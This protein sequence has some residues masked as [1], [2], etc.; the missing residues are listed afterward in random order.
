VQWLSRLAV[1]L[2]RPPTETR[3]L[4]G[5]VSAAGNGALLLGVLVLITVTVVTCMLEAF[6]SSVG[7][8][9][10]VV[11]ARD[12]W[13]V[14]YR[15][16]TQEE[17]C[18]DKLPQKVN[19]LASASNL[20]LWD[21]TYRR[22]DAEHVDR[23]ASRRGQD[24]WLGTVLST[25]AVEKAFRLKANRLILG[26][27][28]SDYEVWVDGEKI[29]FGEYL[30]THSPLVLNLSMSRL[31]EARP[32]TV[33]IRIIH[34]AGGLYPDGLGYFRAEG[35]AT[36]SQADRYL[37]VENFEE[38]TRPWFF[39]GVYF[40]MGS[41]FLVLWGMSPRKQECA[42]LAG[43]ALFQAFLQA[44]KSD[45]VSFLFDLGTWNRIHN[46]MSL[47]EGAFALFLGLAFARFRR[48]FFQWGIPAFIAAGIGL[49]LWVTDSVQAERLGVYLDAKVV[50][51]GYLLGAMACF[52][53]T[54]WLEQRMKQRDGIFAVRVRRLLLFGIGLCAIGLSYAFQQSIPSV[55]E[56]TAWPRFMNLI[57]VLYLSAVILKDY[58]EQEKIIERSPVS[59]YHRRP[60]LPTELSGIV[61]VVDIKRSEFLIRA[62]S[63]WGNAG[64]LVNTGLSHMW[65]AATSNEGTVLHSEG[66]AI[67]VFFEHER[68]AAAP[69][70]YRTVQ[71][72]ANALGRFV[73]QLQD[74]GVKLGTTDEIHF[75]A[76]LVEGVVR[77]VWHEYPGGRYPGWSASGTS[78]VFLEA[79]RLMEI[80]QQIDPDRRK[81]LL[82]VSESL[83]EKLPGKWDVRNQ[84]HEA[85]HGEIYT[86]AL[87]RIE[88]VKL[89]KNKD[90]LVS[91]NSGN[92]PE[93]RGARR[94]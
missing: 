20:A 9:P 69:R 26:Y 22:E 39:F 44:S 2:H 90:A 36:S 38:H 4:G 53:Q 61:L 79:A 85:K 55:T 40:V 18:E 81:S 77:P 57:L 59:A 31:A 30:E 24:F 5:R 33:A 91:K 65:S 43:Y 49:F 32:M 14:L 82:I 60:S 63:E 23:V 17:V 48:A 46:M 64:E 19:C 83:A 94:G 34:K 42:Y 1:S 37:R 84:Q 45:E 6:H 11:I 67:T 86:V 21:S 87:E 78:N 89:G 93:R 62:G 7:S 88:S 3:H 12:S 70:A 66:D 51:R 27:L 29:F 25:D 80:E 28:N 73:D 75:R 35:L 68:R 58:R 47:Y 15:S 52:L 71:D 56:Y 74:R 8:Q 76:T 50:P 54:F 72:V 10:S 13:R 92:R 16:A 41:L